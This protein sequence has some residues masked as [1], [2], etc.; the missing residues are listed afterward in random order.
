MSA[1][2]C[3]AYFGLRF[4]VTP[5]EADSLEQRTDP[6]QIAAKRAGLNCYWGNFGGD[7]ERYLLFVGR[8]IGILGLE[9]DLTL[10]T[11]AAEL[12]SLIADTIQRLSS[13]DF[14]DDAGLH[15]EWI[16]DV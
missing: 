4:T 3:V 12:T 11:P 10:D 2:A 6:R 1:N 15:L 7:A 16:A 9:N 5:D 13:A 8:Q 14:K